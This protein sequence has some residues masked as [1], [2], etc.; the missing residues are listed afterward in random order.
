[1]TSPLSHEVFE[2]L[3]LGDPVMDI[4]AHVTSEFL[5]TVTSEPGGCF[6]I[7][8]KEM[9]A[10]IERISAVSELTRIP[11]GSAANVMKGLAGLL[12]ADV[13]ATRFVGM[14]G[15][16]STGAEYRRC[17]EAKGVQAMLLES[18]SGA[19]SACAICLVT[20]DGQRTMRT[21][22]GASLELRSASQLAPNWCPTKD[23]TKGIGGLAALHCEGYCLYR[24]QLAKEVMRACRTAGALVSIDLASFELVRNC[25]SSLM[26][27]LEA[28]L[29]DLVFAN[30]EEA[31]EMA[32]DL[33]LCPASASHA[34]RVA[35]TQGLLLKHAKV[36]IVSLG[37][38]GCTARTA[39]GLSASAPAGGVKVVDTI[40]AGDTF[41]AGFLAAYLLG[42]PLQR[43]AE[44][45]CAAG[46]EAVQVAG[47]EL[48][49]ESWVRLRARA[50]ILM[51]PTSKPAAAAP[52]PA[53]PKAASSK[54]VQPPSSAVD[55][56]KE[57]GGLLAALS[58][59]V[60]ESLRRAWEGCWSRTK[61]GRESY[62]LLYLAGL[63]L[64]ILGVGLLGIRM[65][66]RRTN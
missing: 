58:S 23:V 17:L 19:P 25:K 41:T 47:A 2:V 21:C 65:A 50:A 14:V 34:E 48:N 60:P 45:G 24:P 10:L 7:S 16:D 18:E 46:S 31:A 29:I 30:E 3:G 64:C 52:E 49:P 35:A 56:G 37:P 1:M 51:A 32:V 39:S 59:A 42:C 36:S 38:K 4:L 62:R 11:G 53:A 55:Q 63:P 26:E 22:L 61:E 27:I 8:P 13:V 28:G 33:Q 43:C 15:K 12:G 54:V 5:A 40:G 66:Q 9:V 44:M 6:A 20:P 57:K